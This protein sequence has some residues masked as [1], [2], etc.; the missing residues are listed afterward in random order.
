[1]IKGWAWYHLKYDAVFQQA[2]LLF[3]HPTPLPI[4]VVWIL[5]GWGG[6][7]RQGLGDTRHIIPAILKQ[8]FTSRTQFY[9]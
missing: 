5:G 4:E 2:K 6:G 8:G 1:M 7:T 3:H 9:C